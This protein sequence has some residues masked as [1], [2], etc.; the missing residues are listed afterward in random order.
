M[1]RKA[2][3]PAAGFGTRFLPA[4]KAI[5]KEMLPLIDT[6]VIQV[7]VEEA[8]AAGITDILIVT[9]KSKEII[10]KHFDYSPELMAILEKKDKALFESVKKISELANIQ[11]VVQPEQNGLGDAIRY[12]RTFVGDDDF[13]VL[14]G[15]VIMKN[16]V[17]SMKLLCDVY[18]RYKK[19]VIGVEQV[20]MSEVVNCGVV[21]PA[22]FEA[23][24]DIYK[25]KGMVEKP[26]VETAPSNLAL[27]GRYVLP[28][29][30][31]DLIDKVELNRGEIQITDAINILCKKQTVLACD[32]TGV[33]YDIGNKITYVK[34]LVEFALEREDMKDEF[35]AYL[36]ELLNRKK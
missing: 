35:R 19:P 33:R 26:S 15:D 10:K 23:E 4:T 5:P 3:I 8:V 2:V 16:S 27:T 7:V 17:P 34:A 22:P 21:D 12:G 29:E 18:E 6:P 30:I 1:I 24:K 9:S 36:E 32:K 25:S 20:P 11:Y 14:L 31:F 28:P 13:A